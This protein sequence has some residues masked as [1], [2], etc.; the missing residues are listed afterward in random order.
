[1]AEA[2][3]TAEGDLGRSPIAHLLVYAL[4]RR[5]TGALF[6]TTPD[7]AKHVVRL[8]RGIPVKVRPGDAYALLGGMLVEA[9]AID[10]AT[11]D[12]ALATAG[13]LGDVL[14][15]AGRIERDTLEQIA[16]QQ[17][18]RRMVRLFE[19][20]KETTYA[21]FDG[22]EELS[23]WGGDPACVDALALIWAGLRMHGER[24]AMMETTLALLGDKPMRLHAAAT[25]SRC[26][27]DEAEAKLA[28]LLAS[29]P[30]TLAELDA[31]GAAPPEMVRRFAYAALITRQIDLGAG[32]LPLGASEPARSNATPSVAQASAAVARMQLKSTV[33]RVGAAAPDAPGDGE[34]GTT[35]ASRTSSRKAREGSAK[36]D[37]APDSSVTSSGPRS[38]EPPSSRPEETPAT[39]RS[40]VSSD[41]SPPASPLVEAAR[42]LGIV[43]VPADAS[44]TGTL[45]SETPKDTRAAAPPSPP[46]PDPFADKSVAELLAAARERLSARDA[47]GAVDACEAARKAAPDDADVIAL[48]AWARFQANPASAKALTVELDDVLV[49]HEGHVTAR[50]YRAMLRKR[51]SDQAGCVR[52]LEKVLELAPSHADAARELAVLAPKPVEK[53]RPSLFGRLFKR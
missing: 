49:A 47:K 38:V 40:S 6:L 35:V 10:Q 18:I 31:L 44:P 19:L 16:E 48:T 11:L 21:Y 7:G 26:G 17:F 25:L 9:G 8:A 43:A 13:L 52:D 37:C 4:D 50:Y 33:H 12:A 29:R 41:P 5:L 22:H 53:G 32:A 2:S 28:E 51:I 45:R 42:E 34:R 14:L 30:V 36:A 23:D 24:S 1:M 15:L 39:A 46:A 20:P 27:L 3:A